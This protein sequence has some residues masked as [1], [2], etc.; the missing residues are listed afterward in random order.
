MGVSWNNVPTVQQHSGHSRK[1]FP[2]R[3]QK[4]DV[5]RFLTKRV[6][7]LC[8]QQILLTNSAKHRGEISKELLFHGKFYL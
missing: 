6:L 1:L 4:V 8:D 5:L 2:Q 3:V 7:K